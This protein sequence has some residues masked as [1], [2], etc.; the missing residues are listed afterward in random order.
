MKSV[1]RK[2]LPHTLIKK[3]KF[4]VDSLDQKIFPFFARN[5]FLSSVYYCLFSTQFRR[6]HQAVLQGRLRYEASLNDIKSS[7]IL[8]VSLKS[9]PTLV[10]FIAS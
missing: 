2:L 4:A 9:S 10:Y 5:A 6:E 7:S 8:I 1:L 3:L